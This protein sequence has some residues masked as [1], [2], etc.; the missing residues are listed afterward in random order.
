[1]SSWKANLEEGLR[2][3]LRAG[4]QREPFGDVTEGAKDAPSFLY[5]NLVPDVN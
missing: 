3:E 4:G 2:A 5:H 1:L